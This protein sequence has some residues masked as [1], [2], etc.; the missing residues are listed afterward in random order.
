MVDLKKQ[1]FDKYH[2]VW[3]DPLYRQRSHGLELWEKYPQFFPEHFGSAL[4]I[5]CGLGLLYGFWNEI[6]FDAWG[7]D[8]VPNCLHED[9]REKWGQKFSQQCLWEMEFDRIFDLGVCTDVMEHIPSEKVSAVFERI[10]QCCKEVVFKIAQH[11][12]YCDLGGPPLHLTIQSTDWWIQ[13]MKKIG[14]IVIELDFV[15]EPQFPNTVIRWNI[16]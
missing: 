13:E 4:D 6:G 14:G 16:C 15:P 12:S 1:E 7:V 5:G 3:D 10:A 11:P 8:H 2:R 9:V